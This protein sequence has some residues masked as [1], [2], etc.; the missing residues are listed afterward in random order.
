M[1]DLPPKLGRSVYAMPTFEEFQA[2]AQAERGIPPI[3]ME[4]LKWV[5]MHPDQEKILFPHPAKVRA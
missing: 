1:M 3:G 4:M 5:A 2:A